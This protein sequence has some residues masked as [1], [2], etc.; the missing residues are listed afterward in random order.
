MILVGV[1]EVGR[2]A[3]AG[4]VL[5][6]AVCL[7]EA[8][9]VPIFKDSKQLSELNRTKLYDW[10]IEHAYFGIGYQS[11]KKIDQIN[12]LQ[13]TLV[14]M[15]RAVSQLIYKAKKTLLISPNQFHVI[16]DGTHI[17]KQMVCSAESKIKADQHIQEVAAASILAKVFRDKLMQRYHSKYPNYSFNTNKGYGSQ[18]HREAIRLTGI[19][20]QHRKSFQLYKP[21]PL[22]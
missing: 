10:I 7:Q 14:A 9:E 4:P 6:A 16:V 15:R 22:F 2:G 8:K 3:L 5:A 17:P 21:I 11:S 1:D 20:P 18:V 12:I 13:A 19:S